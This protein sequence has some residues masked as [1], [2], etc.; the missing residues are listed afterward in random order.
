MGSPSCVRSRMKLL[1]VEDDRLQRRMLREMLEEEYEIVEAED[2]DQALSL[3]EELEDECR[4]V[5]T[6]YLMPGMDGL[7]LTSMIK[8]LHPSLPVVVITAHPSVDNVLEALRRGASNFVLKPVEKEALLEILRKSTRIW[9]E[10]AGR[11]QLLPYLRRITEVEGPLEESSLIPLFSLLKS[12]AVFVGFE[13]AVVDTNLFIGLSEALS[14]A[15]EHGGGEK[16]KAVVRV[17][18]EVASDCVRIEVEDDGRGFS[19]D[20]LPD[21]TSPANISNRRGRG[22]FLMKA[23]MDEVRFEK[24]GRK[25]VLVKYNHAAG[26]RGSA[27][28][29]GPSGSGPSEQEKGEKSQH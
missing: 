5:L 25:V 10:C 20:R 14:N 2:A 3:L 21:P 8:R 23:Y 4:I 29:S 16:G 17:R 22:I 13:R 28:S 15:L 24:G 9:D 19:P 11:E 18:M 7:R 1:L 26:E 12:D 27:V 6:D